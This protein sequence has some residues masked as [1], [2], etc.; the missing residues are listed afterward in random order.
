M[1]GLLNP[2]I[3]VEEGMTA[4]AA[5]NGRRDTNEASGPKATDFHFQSGVPPCH[6][7]AVEAQISGTAQRLQVAD[8]L[9]G[10]LASAHIQ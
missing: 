9:Q 10:A 8:M 6:S 4:A 3:L 5:A 2:L 7:I 1:H